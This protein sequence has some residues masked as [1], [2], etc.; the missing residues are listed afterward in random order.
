[1]IGFRYEK[2]ISCY[3]KILSK[4]S[5]TFKKHEMSLLSVLFSVWA[6]GRAEIR[7]TEGWIVGDV[8]NSEM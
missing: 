4:V 6:G 1:M 3:Y 5:V 8:E 2:N 7:R